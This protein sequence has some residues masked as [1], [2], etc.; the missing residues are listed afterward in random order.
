MVKSPIECRRQLPHEIRFIVAT[1]LPRRTMPVCFGYIRVYHHRAARAVH[2][3]HRPFP[4][5]SE[6]CS[7]TNTLSRLRDESI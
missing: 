6:L 7:C 3:S 2:Q 1:N 4:L 5:L